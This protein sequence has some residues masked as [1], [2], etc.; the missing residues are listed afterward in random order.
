MPRLK[1]VAPV[2]AAAALLCVGV[3]VYDMPHDKSEPPIIGVVRATEISIAPEVGGQ[4]ASLA[5]AKGARV[6]AGQ[7]LAE[8]SAVEL[9]AQ[10]DQAR[11][12]L[13][14][15][16]ASRD[17]V[18]AGVRQEQVA[19]LKN[20]IDKSNARLEYAHVQLSRTSTLASKN[21]ESP[22]ALDQA[23]HDADSARMALT[24]AQASYDAAAAGPTRE[25]RA[26]ADAQ[27]QAAVAAVAE[28]ERRLDKMVMHAPMD[29]VVSVVVAEVGENIRPGQPVLTILATGQDWLSFN[30]RED[31]LGVLTV[32]TTV[33]IGAAGMP[34]TFKA[35][36]TEMR[37][38]GAF[39]T[40]QAAKVVGDYDRSTFR[41][42]VDPSAQH[43]NLEPGMTVWIDRWDAAEMSVPVR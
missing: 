14:A 11:A 33:T 28:L 32:G 41:L 42:R 17:N 3:A 27:V 5:V 35:R 4:L 7:V 34:G 40:W 6:Q 13:A 21:F 10:L 36:V 12:A 18:Y 25:E 31:H 43:P 1:I 26:I 2:I 23:Q 38:L 20:E 22:Q 15:A 24:Q 16:R 30:V 9:A 39:A 29:G 19:S 8:L 37:R